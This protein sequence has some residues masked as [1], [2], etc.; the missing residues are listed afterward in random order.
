MSN[1]VDPD[2]KAHYE[3]SHQDLCCLQKSVIT[4]CGRERVNPSMSSGHFYHKSLE[5]SVSNSM[6]SG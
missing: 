1:I 6:G 5:R 4:A 2:E 3:P